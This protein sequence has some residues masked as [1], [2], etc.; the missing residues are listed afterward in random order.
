LE[1]EDSDISIQ[2][3]IVAKNIDYII[4]A[5]FYI[6]KS[7]LK[8]VGIFSEDYFLYFEEIDYCMRARKFGYRIYPVS[9]SVVYHKEGASTKKMSKGVIS[10]YFS[11]KNRLV[12]S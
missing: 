10:D 7:V 2:N 1:G 3:E 4:G 9:N 5:S 11:I 6:T 8:D 12:V